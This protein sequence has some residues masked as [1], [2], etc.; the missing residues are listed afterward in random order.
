[1]EGPIS[2]NRESI[3]LN[4]ESTYSFTYLSV[5]YKA[6]IGGLGY[7]SAG[8]G[9]LL[10]NVSEFL[11]DKVGDKVG[12]KNTNTEK[13]LMD[14]VTFH[15][16]VGESSGKA[17]VDVVVV[18]KLIKALI[19]AAKEGK[20]QLKVGG[21]RKRRRKRRRKSKRK[22]KRK[23]KRRRKSKKR[24]KTKRKTKRRRRKR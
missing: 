10:N 24:R 22:T 20:A 4:R 7:S 14:A 18:E 12:D 23:T 15:K 5:N 13:D 9:T 16:I 21:G 3:S 8:D 2:L 17:I 11:V 6:I 19:A 1:M